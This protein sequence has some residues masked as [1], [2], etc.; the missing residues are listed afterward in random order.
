MVLG[1]SGAG[2]TIASNYASRVRE[3]ADIGAALAILETEVCVSLRPLPV[4]L[5]RAA[6]HSRGPARVLL[7]TAAAGIRDGRP[8][9]EAWSRGLDAAIEQSSLTDE[10]GGIIRELGSRLGSSPAPDQQRHMRDVAARVSLCEAEARQRQAREGR[11]WG[12]A[13]VLGGL[14][15]AAILL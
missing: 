12:Y 13:G 8:A 11:L 2:L 15:L 10:D 6:E 9:G 14:A 5:E 7:R 4:A 1:F 3:L